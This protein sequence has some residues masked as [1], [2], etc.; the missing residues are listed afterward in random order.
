M[1]LMQ[2]GSRFLDRK[3]DLANAAQVRYWRGSA[4]VDFEAELS[5]TPIGSALSGDVTQ[6]W[7]TT[8]ILVY[9]S[10]LVLGGHAIDPERGDRVEA[11]ING[12][13]VKFV[14]AETDDKRTHRWVDA[15]TRLK[16]RIHMREAA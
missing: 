2:R 12:E 14:V 5:N 15:T 3:M 10:D 6:T 13:L 11:T 7:Q 4:F 1:N 8:D 9:V 16:H